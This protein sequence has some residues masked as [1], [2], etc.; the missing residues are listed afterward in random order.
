MSSLTE[1]RRR[2]PSPLASRASS[3]ARLA[4]YLSGAFALLVAAIL[5]LFAYQAGLFEQFAATPPK[6]P[7]AAEQ[8]EKITVG[9]STITGFDEEHQ[10]YS[11]TARSAVQ[12]KD[13][14]SHVH[15]EAL[16]G[17]SHRANGDTIDMRAE[18]GLYDT[19][20]KNLSLSG[21][22]MIASRD[23]FTAR[24]D[25]ARVDVNK[26]E[27]E[28]QSPVEVELPGGGKITAKTLKITNNGDNVLFSGG[29]RAKFK[30]SPTKGNGTL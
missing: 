15:L 22:V 18:R 20:A 28:S 23:R 17:E 26:K 13:V 12:D 9:P 29:V 10:P 6:P 8:V 7:P 14:P 5:A 27:L 3:R 21:S 24:M 16:S 11:M 30:S 2:S 1:G 19:E 4:P 25:S